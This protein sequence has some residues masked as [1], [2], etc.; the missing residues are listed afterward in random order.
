VLALP[1]SLWSSAQ[2]HQTSS[3]R[4]IMWCQSQLSASHVLCMCMISR[5]EWKHSFLFMLGAIFPMFSCLS[6][7]SSPTRMLHHSLP[8]PWEMPQAAACPTVTVWFVHLYAAPQPPP[9]L[10]DTTGTCL[11]HSDCLVC[12]A[13]SICRCQRALAQAKQWSCGHQIIVRTSWH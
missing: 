1:I 6:L 9:A 4:E 2:W 13:S 8:E 11:F 7:A 10:G 3:S 12:P 5:W